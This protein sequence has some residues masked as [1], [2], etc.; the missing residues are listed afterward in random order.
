MKELQERLGTAIILITHDLGVVAEIADRI[1]VMYA[2]KV[3]ESGTVDEI[4][5][6]PRHPYTWGLLQSMPRLD[7]EKS[8]ELTPVFGT[9]PELTNPPPGC[10][11]VTRCKYA[12]KI[13]Q[14]EM[15][16]IACPTLSHR[17]FCWLEH[18]MA[19]TVHFVKS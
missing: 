14:Q 1:V 9:P 17:V 15:P 6:R 13:C 7:Q 11:F 18:P 3:V 4:F 10:P 12:M 2:G 5:Y 8:R 19:P 16:D